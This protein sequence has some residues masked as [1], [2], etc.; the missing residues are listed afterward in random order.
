MGEV[1]ALAERGEVAASVVAGVLVEM[2]GGKDDVGRSQGQG[3]KAGQR[4]LEGGKPGRGRQSSRPPAAMVAPALP[5]FVPPEPI[6][7]D[8]DHLP[9]RSPA[10]LAAAA[11][12]FEADHL[13]QLVPVDRV[14]PTLTGTDRHDDSMSHL[15]REQKR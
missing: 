12:T 11:G 5:R 7:A 8:D 9:V 6:K 1:A 14:E 3:G 13:R 15:S 4:R 10:M 2:S